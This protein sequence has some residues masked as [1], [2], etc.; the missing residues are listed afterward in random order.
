M[1]WRESGPNPSD[2]STESWDSVADDWV[3]HA[4]SND[5]RQHFLLPLALRM[6]GDVRGKRILDLGCGEGG[7]ARELARHG[8]TVVGVDGSA[9]LIE[10][11]RERTRA[12]ALDIEFHCANASAM[13]EMEALSFD[14][15]LAA[16]SLMDVEDY[17]SSVHEVNRV[18]L[19]GGELLMSITHP[20]FTA[21]IS[22]WER[23]QAGR[24]LV[25]K[26]DRYFERIAWREWM[27]AKF[28]VPVLRR[29]RP[30]EDY[31]AAPLE[32]G[33][34]LRDFREP[35]PDSEQMKLSPRFAKIGRIPYFLFMRWQK[36]HRDLGLT[37]GSH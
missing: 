19:P 15:V 9:R 14:N 3:A 25:F 31:M 36:P 22:Q 33:F 23:D 13:H 5:Y 28:K 6:L 26:V 1:A 2:T 37:S 30:L 11:A 27:T 35:V 20:C 7:Y 18:L 21:P 17:P 4:D 16:M 34:I 32:A 12:E 29:H 8:A 10:I 24:P